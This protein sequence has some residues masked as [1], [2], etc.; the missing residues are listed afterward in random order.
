MVNNQYEQWQAGSQVVY[1]VFTGKK[2]NLGCKW[3]RSGASK[4]KVIPAV[5]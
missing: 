3:N 4:D 2:H 1:R 5:Y